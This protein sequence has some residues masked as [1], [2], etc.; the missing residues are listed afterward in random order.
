MNLLRKRIILFFTT[1][2]VS[3]LF[4]APTLVPGRLGEQWISKPLSLGL[5][6]R[7]GVHL[8]YEVQAR[9]AIAG[10]LQRAADAIRRDLRKDKIAIV[11]SL[12]TKDSQLELTLL[13]SS[14]AERA[15]NKSVELFR[16]LEF[17][18]QRSDGERV[19]LSFS[20]GPAEMN[21]KENEAVNQAVETLRSRIDQ[22]GVTEP[23]ILRSGAERIVVQMPGTTDIEKVKRII[24]SVAKLEFRLVATPESE[25]KVSVKEK[26]GSSLAVEDRALMTGD[27]VDDARVD[28]ADSGVEVSLKFTSEGARTFRAITSENVGRQL[29]II[30]DGVVYS[31][32]QI[33]EAIGGGMASISGS[34]STGEAKDLAVV[35]RSGALPAPLKV[36]EERA[37]GPTLGRE[38]IHKG[39]MAILAGF[40]AIILF[41][42]A[43]YKKAG[44]VAV[45]ALALN[46]FFLLAALSAFGATLTLPGLAG[47]ALT[48]GMAVDSNVIIFERIRE[49]LR[50][51]ANR[52]G[53]VQFGFQ[54]AY[55]AILD[56]NLSTLLTAAILYY[57]GTGPIRGFAVTLAVGILTTLFCAVFVTRLA[58]DCFSLKDRE[59]LSVFPISVLRKVFR[60]KPNFDFIG[61]RKAA[62]ALSAILV[63]CSGYLW[64]SQGNEKYGIDFRGGHEVIVR[65]SEPATVQKLQSLLPAAGFSEANVQSFESGSGE[66]AIRIGGHEDESSASVGG[67]IK[68]ALDRSYQKGVEILGTGFVGP[69]IGEELRQDAFWAVAIGLLGI[70][71]YVSLR[72][73]FAFALGAVVA[74]FHDVIVSVGVYLLAGNQLTMAALAAALTIVGYS[75]NDTIVIFD[76]VREEIQKRESVDLYELFNTSLN[77]TFSRTI[78]TSLLTLFS[79][80]AL[81]LIG[82]GALKDLSLL[83]VAGLIAGSYST[84]YI[85]SPVVI[86]WH[87]VCR[88]LQ[89]TDRAEKAIDEKGGEI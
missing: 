1:V 41:M 79:A 22:F 77:L 48:V 21:R 37:V 5:D 89:R 15:K 75:V 70:L 6:L 26:N 54:S 17:K 57:F 69:V 25:S 47:L 3:L 4:L 30:L 63:L 60:G 61:K 66:F 33:R 71:A 62:I 81:L 16:D 51:G 78:I 8:V 53:A 2:I 44:A 7:G 20:L 52:N 58:L 13:S 50:K 23:T 88:R 18:G 85:A 55:S 74:L 87:N 72:F 19:V 39:I 28:F 10:Y 86:A 82:G 49:E 65:A 14:S 36:L 42:G 34:F 38:S 73:E 35:L 32:P 68:E 11:K 27:S 46:I 80:A 31:A 56:T 40:A 24:G 12:V 59:G 43:Y 67:K 9:E 45:V 83:L 84:I 29:A 76:R 64:F